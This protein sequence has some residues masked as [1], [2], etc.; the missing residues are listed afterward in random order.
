ML[1]YLPPRLGC[2]VCDGCHKL[3]FEWPIIF[4]T[5]AGPYIFWTNQRSVKQLTHLPRF[6]PHNPAWRFGLLPG[7]ACGTNLLRFCICLRDGSCG[8]GDLV[9]PQFG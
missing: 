3:L 9:A 5:P 1:S 7:G 6:G 8:G 4:W 2:D